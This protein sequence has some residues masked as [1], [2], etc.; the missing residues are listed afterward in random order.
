[1]VDTIR[2]AKKSTFLKS[3]SFWEN[4]IDLKEK[5]ETKETSPV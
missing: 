5:N 1:M 3:T 2:E 4:N